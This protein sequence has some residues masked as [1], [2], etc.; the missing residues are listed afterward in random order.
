MLCKGTTLIFGDACSRGD[1]HTLP[2]L[3]L[4]LLL[5]YLHDALQRLRLGVVE[6]WE[7]CA[8]APAAQEGQHLVQGVR[9][10][11]TL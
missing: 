11:I 3:L 5:S 6:P 10:A 1:G 9:A 2:Q 4:V 7:A 8:R